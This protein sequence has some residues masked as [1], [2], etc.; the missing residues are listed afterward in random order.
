MTT[1]GVMGAL[2]EWMPPVLLSLH[3]LWPQDMDEWDRR[4]QQ[5][6][7]PPQ[8]QEQQPY[9]QYLGRQQQQQPMRQRQPEQQ[10]Q[11]GRYNR[12]Q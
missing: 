7:P 5:K 10:Q 2:C 8:Q 1:E 3:C 12:R 4:M 11:W 6:Q 9:D